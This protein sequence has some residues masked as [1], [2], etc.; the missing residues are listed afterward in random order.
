MTD[1]VKVLMEYRKNDKVY[2]IIECI[3]GGHERA[4][5][6]VQKGR[7]IS[8]ITYKSSLPDGVFSDFRKLYLELFL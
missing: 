8:F 1:T 4:F 7:N 6:V 5:R 3:D 2:Q